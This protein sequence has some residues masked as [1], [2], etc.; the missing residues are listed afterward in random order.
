M[1][2]TT[3]LA[4]L[5]PLALA[6]P[7]CGVLTAKLE[8]KTVCATLVDYELP[9]ADQSG[10]V[11]TDV[12]YDLGKNVPLLSDSGTTY[13]LELQSVELSLGSDSGLTD[14]GG[15]EEA[16]VNVRSPLGASLPEPVLVSYARGADLH[17]TAVVVDSPSGLDLRPYVQDSQVSLHLHAAGTLPTQPWR[18]TMKACF[19]L[20]VTLD[21]GKKL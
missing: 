1:N 7:G 21:Y 8:A 14:L 11:D 10:V 19:G 4:A 13:A 5:A 12:A 3:L 9:G 6:L 18:A 17:Q 16:A 20:E 2:R 15:L